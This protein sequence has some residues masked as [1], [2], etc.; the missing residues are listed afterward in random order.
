MLIDNMFIDRLTKQKD[1]LVNF[2]SV[3]TD[4]HCSVA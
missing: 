2:T 3:T 4:K 1:L